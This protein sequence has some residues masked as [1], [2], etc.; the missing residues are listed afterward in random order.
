MTLRFLFTAVL[1]LSTLSSA[2]PSQT[3]VVDIN[4]GPGTTH[5]SVAAA[6]AAAPDGSTI[7][8]RSG[9]YVEPALTITGKSIALHGAASFGPQV[10]RIVLP[11][12]AAV[13]VETLVASQRVVLSDCAVESSAVNGV[14]EIQCVDNRGRVLLSNFPGVDSS[15]GLRATDCDWLIASHC[16]F[17]EGAVR[18]TDSN[19]VLDSCGIGG[20]YQVLCVQTGGRVQLV[21]SSVAGPPF[22][23]GAPATAY[24]LQGGEVVVDGDS[25]VRGGV[26]LPLSNRGPCFVGF[27]TMR[28]DPRAGLSGS[29][30]L[31]PSTI[32][33][34][35]I[36]MPIL[37]A[38]TA[39]LGGNIPARLYG[40]LGHLGAIAVS[41]P[42]LVSAVPPIPGP[43]WLDPVSVVVQGIGTPAPLQPV[44]TVTTVPND[45]TLRGLE[46][47]WQAFTFEATVGLQAS[48][49]AVRFLR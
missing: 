49:P 48:N 25:S 28:L 14:V 9:Q 17:H 20:F 23:F 5:T 27:G 24:R 47:A 35:T 26:Q 2:L 8:V 34:T 38:G 1:S 6:L 31:I 39:A 30:P 4:N 11:P 37:E 29:G 15:S 36:E 41:F 45:P 13:R 44:T 22:N 43:V 46:L 3:L 10:T 7:L 32:S 21:G 12:G 16:A 19:V 33:V 18:C 40:P 42:S